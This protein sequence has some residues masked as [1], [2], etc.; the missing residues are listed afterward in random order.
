MVGGEVVDGPDRRPIH[1]GK[2]R[3]AEIRFTFED[4]KGATRA[5]AGTV[6]GNEIAG[7]LGGPGGE[8]ELRGTLHG[9]LRPA[10]W[11]EMPATCAHFYGK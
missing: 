6:R 2:L 1:D 3:G 8:A 10:P 7:K 9:A 11:A 5:F 4:E